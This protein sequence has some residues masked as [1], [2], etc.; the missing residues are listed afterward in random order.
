MTCH[1]PRG[2]P[3]DCAWLLD[4]IIRADPE[5]MVEVERWRVFPGFRALLSRFD[6]ERAAI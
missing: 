6:T 4:P 3:L 1:A 5:R 2:V